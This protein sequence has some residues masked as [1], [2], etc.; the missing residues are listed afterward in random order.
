MNFSDR[1]NPGESKLRNFII[2]ILHLCQAQEWTMEDR[3]GL[4]HQGKFDMV[5][6]C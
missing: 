1:V 5:K 4:I 6:N 3:Q 2:E